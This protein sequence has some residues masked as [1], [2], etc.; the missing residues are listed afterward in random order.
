MNSKTTDK[1]PS[2][3][4]DRPDRKF[5]RPQDVEEPRSAYQL[6]KALDVSSNQS[7]ESLR[8]LLQED[9]FTDLHAAVI[10]SQAALC[11][12]T[13]LK[14]APSLL[15]VLVDRLTPD[16]FYGS[17]TSVFSELDGRIVGR[18][19]GRRFAPMQKTL[20]AF[21]AKPPTNTNQALSFL[22]AQANAHRA[23]QLATVEALPA[24]SRSATFFAYALI[25]TSPAAQ[26]VQMMIK[27]NI[28][29]RLMAESLMSTVDDEITAIASRRMPSAFRR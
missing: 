2:R 10:R 29:L 27:E 28:E 4:F 14:E 26:G 24:K 9:R 22:R 21:C 15:E 3:K 13:S 8:S 1:N 16:H 19:D 20:E 12:L 18:A 6:R 23:C 25:A 17:D 7:S 5:D 11:A